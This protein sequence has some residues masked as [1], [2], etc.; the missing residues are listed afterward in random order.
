MRSPTVQ[1]IDVLVPTRSTRR[2][3][4][5][6]SDPIGGRVVHRRPD[7]LSPSELRHLQ[8]SAGNVAVASLLAAG[9]QPGRPAIQRCCSGAAMCGPCAEENVTAQEQSPTGAPG[10]KHKGE[11]V[12]DDQIK[13]KGEPVADDGIKTARAEPTGGAVEYVDGVPIAFTTAISAGE[14]AGELAAKTKKCPPA[15]GKIQTVFPQAR[16][17]GAQIGAMGACTWGITA[18][19][20]LVVTTRTC[21]DGAGN[22]TLRVQGVTSRIRTFSQL[23]A[24]QAEAT[25][26]SSTSGNFCPQVHELDVLGTCA[27]AWYMLSAVRAHERVHVQEWKTSFPADWPAVKATLEGLTVPK[28]GATAAQKAATAALR[29]LPAFTSALRTNAVNFPTFWAI[30]DPNPSTNAA[31]RAVVD[32]RITAICNK[33]KTKKWNPGACAECSARGFV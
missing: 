31:E 10:G 19:D 11:P 21:E 25:T 33:A 7:L 13:T 20:D 14:P 5:A 16:S 32:P 6:V 18:P 3:E 27:G 29:A 9:R 28:A 4:S 12:A 1:E 15:G 22:W 17:T 2:V 24:G 26:A 23:L 30:P 8:R